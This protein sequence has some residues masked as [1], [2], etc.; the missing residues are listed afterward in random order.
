MEPQDADEVSRRRKRKAAEETGSYILRNLAGHV[1]LFSEEDASTVQISCVELW[2]GNLY[3]GTSAAEILHFVLI[4]PDPAEPSAPPSFILASRLRPVFTQSSTSTNAQGGVQQILLLPAVSKAC[5]LCNGT[6]TFY[7]LPELSPAFGNTKVSN[8]G[9]IG[10]LDLN[11]PEII[12]ASGHE[13]VVVMLSLRNRIRLVIIGEEARPI[14]NIEYARSLA[15]MRRS[16]VACV[17]DSHSY[18]LLEINHQQKIPL[19][20]ISSL[21]DAAAGSTGG[22]AE[23]LSAGQEQTGVG[24][25]LAAQSLSPEGSGNTRGHDRST[26]L[27]VLAGGLGRREHSPRAASMDTSG[28]E[29]PEPF[30]RELSPGPVDP[31]GAFERGLSPVGRIATPDKPLPATPVEQAASQRTSA[32]RARTDDIFL[33]PHIL[34]PTPTEFL[35]TTGTAAKEPGVGMFV[36][37]DGD[38][39][40]G[41]LEFSRYP[42]GIV[43]D[44]RGSGSDT[45]ALNQEEG[46]VLAVMERDHS[47]G[48]GRG[49]EVQRWDMENGEGGSAKEWI[50]V[51][52][53]GKE[54]TGSEEQDSS[55]ASLGI[56]EIVG[57]GEIPISELGQKLRLSRLRLPKRGSPV[58]TPTSADDPTQASLEHVSKEI[59]LFESRISVEDR[60][61]EDGEDGQP[62]DEY[63][64]SREKEEDKFA[65]RLCMTSSRIVLWSGNQ[66]WWAIRNPLVLRLDALLELADAGAEIDS[67][68]V[69]DWRKVVEVVNSIRGQEPKTE[70]EF[71]SLG[72]IRHKAGL[73][74]FTDLVSKRIA[75]APVDEAERRATEELLVEGSLDP[76]L[77]LAAISPLGQEVVEGRNGIWVSAGIKDVLD[78]FFDRRA[79]RGQEDASSLA[80]TADVLD[81]LK[82]YLFVWRRKKGFGSIADE[83]DVFRT[84][85]AALLHVLLQL[86]RQNLRTPGTTSV[87]AE[88]YSVVDHGVACFERA[89]WLL[90]R[91][92]RLYV[93][94]RLY[95][96]RKMSREV[97][98]TWRR[99]VEGEPDEAGEFTDGENEVRKYLVKIR[100]ARLI[101]EYG[102]WLARRNPK[103]GVL[104]FADDN[105]RFKFEPPRVVQMLKEGAPGAVKDYLEHLVFGKNHTQYVN[106]LIRFYLDTVLDV[107]EKSDAARSTLAQTYETYRA[108]RPPKPT[109]RQFITENIVDEE[110]WHNRLRL[111]QLLGGSH[112]GG[113][114][115]S[116]SQYDVSAVLSRIEPF[117]DELVPEMIILYGRQGRH[118]QALRLLTHGL[119]DFD[120]AINYCLL[121]GSSIF[122]PSS[123]SQLGADALPS[124]AEQARLFDFLLAEFL[125]IDNVSD[126]VERTGELLE[127]FG[128][129]FDLEHVLAVIPDDWSVD[130]VAGF[131]VSTLRGLV[132]ERSE[133]MLARALSGAQ[134]LQVSAALIEKADA[135]GPVVVGGGGG[136]GSGSGGGSGG[137]LD[138]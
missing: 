33:R 76:R 85:D 4:P 122:R 124:Q 110:W 88:L 32:E 79:G 97:L 55:P 127:R 109:Y 22:R 49:V 130:L 59:E 45:A 42:E 133:S 90:E 136:S 107:L 118:Q 114:E 29:T 50:P 82:R 62:V 95:Q 7:T 30:Q 81:L 131:L 56:R 54:S 103:L 101:E 78:R 69:L 52:P 43:I 121:G 93:L 58:P 14:K 128:R 3:I 77:V 24:S 111:L 126:R 21:D 13:G 123:P 91:F 15:S 119:G 105:S 89:I 72:Y 16:T 75:N 135:V 28:L 19:F 106:D 38:V 12:Q 8:C 5:I 98:R 84:V 35:L 31:A 26:S 115:R 44:G 87:R 25:G 10:G 116:A 60:Q 94:S 65:Q 80:S 134:N 108:L 129:W 41:T 18:A 138:E 104:V 27:G 113:A 53:P 34:S 36:N 64:I 9:S 57:S 120:A 125:R 132:R 63:E 39:V 61:A 48:G 83:E 73:L 47:S 17:A 37:L 99:M 66:I 51:V 68:E 100:D 92:R 11:H 46:Y 6:L 40:R 71:L 74:L 96:S 23:N 70:M 86:D 137:G 1:P 67:D 112:G 2:E 20:P 117:E 102:T